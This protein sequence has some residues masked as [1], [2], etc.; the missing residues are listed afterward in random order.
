M[1][2]IAAS[3]S[4]GWI[5]RETGI[6]FGEEYYF[7]PRLRKEVDLK[8]ASFLEQHFSGYAICNLESNL[9]SLPH[10]HPED[11]LVGAIQ[12]NL[13]IGML[14]GAR[15]IAYPDQDADIEEKPLSGI[16]SVQ[17][18][19]EPGELTAHPM[20]KNWLSEI[21]ALKKEGT[22]I[23][24]FFWDRGGRATIHGPLTT[25][26]KFFGQDILFSI[27]DKPDFLPSFFL[28]Y[29][30]V[31]TRL[32][33]TFAR[34]TGMAITGLHI[35]ECSGTMLS[36]SDYGELIIPSLK[37]LGKAIGPIRLHH[38][39]NCTHLLETIAKGAPIAILDTGSGT[40]VAAVRKF[41]G[42]TLPIDLMPPLELLL[43]GTGEVEI[44]EW[45]KKVQADNDGGELTVNYHLEPGYDPQNHLLFHELLTR[46]SNQR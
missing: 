2:R 29:E 15:F 28:W 8:I 23:P 37:R 35:G 3:V 27:Y 38:C 33:F 21:E 44:G 4:K 22:V 46:D 10:Y 41:F 7:S 36:P 9:V 12:P 17:A 34:A 24:P 31:C 40:D 20:V 16:T 5:H 43:P 13:I 42:N 14:L 11:V 32:I 25:A 1:V 6:K 26:L 39:G 19:P 30:E 18:L 45:L